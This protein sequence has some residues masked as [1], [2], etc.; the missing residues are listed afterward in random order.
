MAIDVTKVFCRFRTEQRLTE[1]ECHALCE[2]VTYV[3]AGRDSKAL[4]AD[5]YPKIIAGAGMFTGSRILH[6]LKA[7]GGNHR[8]TEARTRLAYQPS[9]PARTG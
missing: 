2:G 6:H 8:H 7:L 1:A 5:T 3:H 9:R 4:S